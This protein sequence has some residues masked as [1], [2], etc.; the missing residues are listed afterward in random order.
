MKM[1]LMGERDC[2]KTNFHHGSQGWQIVNLPAKFRNLTSTKIE[3]LRST[4]G[5]NDFRNLI[6]IARLLFTQGSR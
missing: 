5:A 2:L 1:A 3:H 4:I 6:P